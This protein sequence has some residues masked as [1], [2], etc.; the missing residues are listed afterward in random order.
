M[1]AAPSNQGVTLVVRVR[2]G[3]NA[4]SIIRRE[5]EALDPTV[6]AFGIRRVSDELHDA[7]FLATF[8]TLMYGGMGAFGL[9][10][11]SV[12]LAGVTAHAVVRRRKE[13]GIR[14]ALGAGPVRVLRLVL[15]ESG[16]IIA[17][18]LA[19]GVL[20]AIVLTRVLASVL[21]AL[22]ETTSTTTTDP[23]ILFGGPALL[24][25]V[26]LAACVIPARDSIRIDPNV[27]LRSE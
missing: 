7:R 17:A 21:E 15:G 25:A 22:A 11:A 5:S 19:T 27:A 12:G 9:I 26:A 16:T 10:L 6:A 2:P 3:T 1:F 18:G 4:A 13:I 20:L 8:G 14:M 24:A 23:L